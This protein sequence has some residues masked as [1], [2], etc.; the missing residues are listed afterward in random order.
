MYLPE[1]LPVGWGLRGSDPGKAK[2]R[3][4]SDGLCL[5]CSL[6][7]LVDLKANSYLFC[8]NVFFLFF[9]GVSNLSYVLPPPLGFTIGLYFT[10]WSW[11]A[12]LVEIQPEAT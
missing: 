4:R 12:P 11:Q 10:T 6:L 9:Q 3:A 8:L 7:G 2:Q 5:S 1:W